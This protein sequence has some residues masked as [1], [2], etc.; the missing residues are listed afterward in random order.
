M[1]NEILELNQEQIKELK[2]RLRNNQANLSQNELIE[3]TIQAAID[4]IFH[5]VVNNGE[6]FTFIWTIW[7][8]ET[9]LGESYKAHV[10][11][12]AIKKINAHDEAMQ[13]YRKA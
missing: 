2:E 12:Q 3:L 1:T 4:N 11:D 6:N 9:T 7:V 8:R 10:K 13:M 5:A